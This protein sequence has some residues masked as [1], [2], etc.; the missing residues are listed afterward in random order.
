M[1]ILTYT[2]SKNPGGYSCDDNEEEI[3]MKMT[4]YNSFNVC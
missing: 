3:H 1:L 2:A 4:L